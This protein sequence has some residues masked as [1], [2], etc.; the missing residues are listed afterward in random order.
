MGMSNRLPDQRTADLGWDGQYIT[1]LADVVQNG[2][3]I[4]PSKGDCHEFIGHSFQLENPRDRITYN[5]AHPLNLVQALGHWLWT[6]AGRMEFE[7]IRYYNPHADQFSVDKFR[8]HGAYGPRIFG[9]GVFNQIDRVIDLIQER[10]WTRRGVA[11]VHLPE[12]D[13]H[14]KKS[15]E[16]EDEVPCTVA[17]Q[18]LPRNG[19]VHGI[20]FMR[21][22]NALQLLPLDV[23]IF[24]LIQEFVAR[25]AGMSLGSYHHHAGSFHTYERDNERISI[26]VKGR[27]PDSRPEMPAMSVGDP[28][29]TLAKILEIEQQIRYE[30]ITARKEQGRRRFDAKKYLNQASDFDD[31]WKL[32]LHALLAKAAVEAKDR[33]LLDSILIKCHSSLKPTL[34]KL[35]GDNFEKTIDQFAFSI[36]E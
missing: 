24:T 36:K 25:A 34:L 8:M 16:A 33:G 14:R 28:R 2:D 26:V 12:F 1:M 13:S 7:S 32:V 27:I 3:I 11:V 9:I 35:R 10:N 31:F 21:S 20:T 5:D 29:P 15:D 23:L 30:T 19:A 4:K 6:M 18:F 17:L 22:Q